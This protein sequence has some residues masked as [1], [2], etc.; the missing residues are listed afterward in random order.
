ML[1]DYNKKV[2]KTASN[3]DRTI[4]IKRKTDDLIPLQQTEDDLANKKSKLDNDN[5]KKIVSM[6]AKYSK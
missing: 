6:H 1:D 3:I 5:D 2:E 4:H